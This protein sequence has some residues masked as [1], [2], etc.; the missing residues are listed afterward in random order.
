MVFASRHSPHIP[1]HQSLMLIGRENLAC[2]ADGA[3]EIHSLFA[4][5]LLDLADFRLNAGIIGL[6]GA[7]QG[8]QL[9]LTLIDL[10]LLRR[11]VKH[12]FFF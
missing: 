7:R 6:I 12:C 11:L 10:A 8:V 5:Q 3:D 9:L 2:L 1:H 4:A